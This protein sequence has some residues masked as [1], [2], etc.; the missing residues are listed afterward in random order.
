MCGQ[1]YLLRQQ[2]VVIVIAVTLDLFADLDAKRL[3]AAGQRTGLRGVQDILIELG[4][5]DLAH[6][7]PYDETCATDGEQRTDKQRK[8]G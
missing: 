6:A 7:V 2:N 4:S 8:Q 1:S 3:A 5:L